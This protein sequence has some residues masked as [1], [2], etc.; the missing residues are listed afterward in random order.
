MFRQQPIAG[1]AK[2]RMR[3][4]GLLDGR[5]DQAGVKRDLALQQRDAKIDIAEHAIARIARGPV[6]RT[7]KQRRRHGAKPLDRGNAELFFAVEVM[8]KLPLVTPAAAQM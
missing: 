8:K 3:R 6:W 2:V 5:A 4:I 1:E 7:R